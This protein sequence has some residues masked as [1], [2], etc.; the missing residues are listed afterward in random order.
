MA[1][2]YCDLTDEQKIA[3]ESALAAYGLT[4]ASAPE[5]INTSDHPG[6]LKVGIGSNCTKTVKVKD[7]DE[8]NGKVGFPCENYVSGKADDS[9]IEYPQDFE[10]SSHAKL[11][12]NADDFRKQLSSEDHKTLSKAMSCCLHGDSNKLAKYKPAINAAFFKQ[13]VTLA[14]HS[15][16]D[17]T[18]TKDN[19]LIVPSDGGKTAHLI[20]GTVTIE[21]G[22]YIQSEV[23]FTL[24]S[25]VFTVE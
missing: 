4:C 10:K 18:I 9:D 22:G 5:A 19:P 12:T 15:T 14:V 25:Q 17:I 23:P 7:I 20:Y 21:P 11:N 13:P 3:H 6:G 24:T 8:L 1:K 16:Q 2:K